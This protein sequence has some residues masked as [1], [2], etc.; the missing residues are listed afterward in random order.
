MHKHRIERVLVEVRR[1][2]ESSGLAFWFKLTCVTKSVFVFLI[3][4]FKKSFP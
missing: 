2:M 1:E 3:L 4:I